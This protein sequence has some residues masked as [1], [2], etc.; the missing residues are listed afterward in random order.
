MNI[1]FIAPPAAGKGTYSKLLKERYHFNH[2]SAGELLRSVANSNSPFSKELNEIMS[3]GEMVNDEFLA[4]LIEEKLKSLDLSVPF[5]MDGYPR[6][7]NQVKDYEKIL[8]KL[9]L[10]LTSIIYIDIDKETGLKRKLSRIVCNNCGKS[11]NLSE[12]TLKPKVDGICDNCKSPLVVRNDDTKEAYEKLC[13]TYINETK[14]VLEYYKSINKLH[15]VDGTKKPEE[16]F[17]EIT[18]FL[19]VNNG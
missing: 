18:D 4:K 16:T 9:N 11:Y 6:K 12:E 5:I 8:K 1:I 7:L 13:D 2:I 3:K 19:G 15:R 17:K 14:P 10:D